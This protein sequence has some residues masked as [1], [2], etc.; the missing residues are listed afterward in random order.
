MCY[1]DTGSN[2]GVF[3]M[4]VPFNE[5][6]YPAVQQWLLDNPQDKSLSEPTK[7]RDLSS[8]SSLSSLGA[9]LSVENVQS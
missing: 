5:V 7:E 1:N 8:L 9:A 3:T 4:Q 6:M 2:M